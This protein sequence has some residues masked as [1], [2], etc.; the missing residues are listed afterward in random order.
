M[1]SSAAENPAPSFSVIPV[2]G[3]ENYEFWKVKMRTLLLSEGLWN[4]VEKGFED[5]DDESGL[6]DAQRKRLDANRMTDARAL[7]K[8]Q[9]GVSPTIFPRI[10]RANTAKQAWET[11]QR[12]FQG[13]S[14]AITVKLQFLRREFENLKMKQ[15]ESVKDYFSRV[16]NVVNQ[17]KTY[18][19]DISDQKIVEKILISLPEKYDYIVVAIEE[20]KDLS[21]LSVE[22][23]MGSLESHEQ[24]R[25]CRSDQSIES[26][27]QSKLNLKPQRSFK[28]GDSSNQQRRWKKNDS[29]KEERK[30]ETVTPKVRLGNGAIVQ[31]K[32]KGSIAVET[33]KGTK[34]VHDVLLVPNLEQNLLSVGQLVENGYRLCF[35]DDGCIIYDRKNKTMAIA[36]VKMTKNRNFFIEFK[37]ESVS[38]FKGEVVEDSWLYMA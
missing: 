23:L 13:D 17:M 29:K 25:Q 19:E 22:Q 21:T 28:K 35:K 33:R 1:A 10:I 20:S 26:A 32:G 18:G 5:P 8:I 2:F 7:S 3:G 16:I 36:S 12:E 24:R 6:S 38:A 14:K 4:I 30:Y 37:Y 11:L 34:H 9:N 31:A 15:S 27:F